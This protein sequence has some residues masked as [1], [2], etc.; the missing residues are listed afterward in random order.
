[1]GGSDERLKIEEEPKVK[2]RQIIAGY[3]H[4]MAIT[5]SGKVY[6]WGYSGFGLLGRVSKGVENIP[7]TIE[8]GFTMDVKKYKVDLPSLEHT[9]AADQDGNIKDVVFIASHSTQITNVQCVSLGTMVLTDKGEIYYT[10]DNRYGQLPFEEEKNQE[11]I[12]GS[13]DT[14]IF[15]QILLPSKLV[16]DIACG[17]DHIFAVTAEDKVYGWGRNDSAQLGIGIQQDYMNEPTLVPAFRDTAVAKIVCG[18]NYSAAI[19]SSNRL[20]VAG[21]M[22]FGKLGLGTNQRN[23]F[24]QDFTLV[25]KL[26]SVKAVSCGPTHMLAI[27]DRKTSSGCGV[28]AWG[29]N[30][31][32]QLGI[33]S[34]ESSYSP[35]EITSLKKSERFDEVC[36]GLDFSLGLSRSSK[37]V[38]MWGNIKYQ[39]QSTSTSNNMHKTPQAI[40]DFENQKIKHIFCS[41]TYA[42]AI[43]E[44]DEIKAWGEWFYERAKETFANEL[45]N[46]TDSDDNAANEEDKKEQ[47]HASIE[48]SDSDDDESSGESDGSGDYDTSSSNASDGG[49]KK[50]IEK[51]RKNKDNAK[52]FHGILSFPDSIQR[53]PDVKLNRLAFGTNHAAGISE[54]GLLYTWGHN[55]CQ[56]LGVSL[57][58][59]GDDSVAE[60]HKQLILTKL[61]ETAINTTLLIP[62]KQ[63]QNEEASAG[64]QAVGN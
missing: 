14:Q 48:S 16:K 4:S 22:E 51:K 45:Q 10:G 50:V 34:T 5:N 38:Y 26:R 19:T 33:D 61:Y 49:D 42:F 47:E 41:Q 3:N 56:Q 12:K 13:E 30:Q 58:K 59:Y 62:N 24:A 46:A 29:N 23:G 32:G 57:K 37:K 36:A 63:R 2:F 60:P 8:S 35:K 20:M 7:V 28:F 64:D 39:G 1:M 6:T 11:Y 53:Q 21:S 9:I 31:M 44:N 17:G 25:S 15:K 52:E 18:P 54:D 43:S 27:V 55:Q 40:K